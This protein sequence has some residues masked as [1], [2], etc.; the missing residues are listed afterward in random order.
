M[1]KLIGLDKQE[2]KI[3]IKPSSYPMRNEAAS[4]SKLQFT[5]GQLLRQKF[6]LSTILEEVHFPKHG[7]ILDFYL[8]KEAIVV[9]VNGKQHDEYVPFFHKNRFHPYQ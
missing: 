6:P 8:P 2:I 7:F 5:C 4:K 1:K 9:E 3:D